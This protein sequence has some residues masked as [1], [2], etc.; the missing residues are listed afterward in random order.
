MPVSL[1]A[2]MFL[3]NAKLDTLSFDIEMKL[4]FFTKKS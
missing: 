1:E 3:R 4:L 2:G